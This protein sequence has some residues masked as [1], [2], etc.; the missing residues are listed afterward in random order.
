MAH[1]V[2]LSGPRLAPGSLPDGWMPAR[3]ARG[4]RAA[5]DLDHKLFSVFQYVVAFE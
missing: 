2:R 1:I 4:P 5:R 3:A